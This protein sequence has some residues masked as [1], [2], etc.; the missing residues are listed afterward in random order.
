MATLPELWANHTPPGAAEA[1]S[2]LLARYAEAHRAYHT[3]QHLAEM[4]QALRALDAD[5]LPP[6][7][8]F[9]LRMAVWFHDAVYDPS[10]PPGANEQ[11][12]AALARAVVTPWA[13]AHDAVERIE[14]LIL[15]TAEHQGAES[16]PVSALM[17][18]ADLWILAS[19]PERFGSYCAQVRAEYAA[20]PD[21]LYRHGRTVILRA[22]VERDR[23]YRSEVAHRSWTR[24]A[25]TNVERELARLH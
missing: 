21:E 3:G 18:D 5:R 22:L 13:P 23:I 15:M 10:A 14:A 19:P 1:G 25:K 4:F 20:V 11:A 7:D 9:V 24:Q 6:A 12:S 17:S 2:E 16:D 8:L